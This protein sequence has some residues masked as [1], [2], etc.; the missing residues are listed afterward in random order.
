M[1]NFEI[2][3]QKG[4]SFAESLSLC[5][6]KKLISIEVEDFADTETCIKLSDVEHIKNKNLC[7]VQHFSFLNK[8]ESNLNS[9]N[10]Q[11]LKFLLLA[12]FLKKAGAKKLIA[13]IPY[14]PYSRQD[15]TYYDR[16]IGAISFIGKIIKTS[17]IEMVISFDLH[18][19][20]IKDD[21]MVELEEI[22]LSDF[23]VEFIKSNFD[24]K[25][26]YLVSP[27]KGHVKTVQRISEKLGVDFGHIKKE[28]IANDQSKALSFVGNVQ[29]KTVVLIDDI[30][31]T[32][33]TSINA[34]KM[35]RDH[36]AKN[37]I[38]CFTHGVFTDNAIEK[39]EQSR[40]EKIF[41]T[42]TVFQRKDVLGCGKVSVISIIDL[43]CNH[44]KKVGF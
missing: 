34:C 32:A 21:F 19:S 8:G 38:A 26:I 12:D 18:E 4:S 9:I 43:L 36:G 41:V 37:I 25:N 13:I 30:I 33:T 20:D 16:Y 39:L 22:L 15:K 1:L 28:R 31:D 44:L 10:N 7:I 11:I 24:T 5:L 3:S 14:L 42:D 27:D 17:G 35:L 23:W 2:I 40:F 6:G 29:D